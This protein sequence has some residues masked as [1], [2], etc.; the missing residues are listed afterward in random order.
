M[1]SRTLSKALRSPL[2]R[3]LATP[4]VQTRTFVSAMGAL[5]ATAVASRTVAR[6]AQQQQQVRGVKTIDFAGSKEEVWGK[7][8][9]CP[10]AVVWRLL[11]LCS[12]S[13]P[14]SVPTGP[15]RSS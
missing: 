10:G 5:R 11:T 6:P 15:R 9:C 2:G 13:H 1:A 14:Q 7:L 8:N 4:A 12:C 3:Q